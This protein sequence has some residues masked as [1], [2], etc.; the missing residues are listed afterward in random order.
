MSNFINLDASRMQSNTQASQSAREQEPNKSDIDAFDDALN[1]P[2]N[3]KK[4]QGTSHGSSEQSNT[5]SGQN[6]FGQMTNPLD[7]LFGNGLTTKE[8]AQASAQSLSSTNA[9]LVETILVSQPGA[10]NQEVRLT[11]GKDVLADTEIRITRDSSGTLNISLQTNNPSSF[12]TLVAGQHDLKAMLERGEGDI[13]ITVESGDA[14][15][16]D[17]NQ[18]S[19]GYNEYDAEEK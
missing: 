2:A 15:Q 3:S 17:T 5:A 9:K 11:L 4:E 8:T 6:S 7:A 18:R 16:N 12:Q 14:E 10:D 1:E 13:K 19:R